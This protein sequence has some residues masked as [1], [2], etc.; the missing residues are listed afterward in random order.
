MLCL[1]GCDAGTGSRTAR[2]H[3]QRDGPD[4]NGT[5]IDPFGGAAIFAGVLR[6]VSSSFSEDPLRVLRVARFAARFGFVVAP[7]TEA[8]MRELSASGELA[9]L[10]P[11][12]VWQELSRG[13]MEES[14]RGCWVLCDCGAL[15][16]LLPEID[17][18][19]G[20]LN[21]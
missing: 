2:H 12:R 13:L 20:C 15:A 7:A 4:E 16:A 10:S 14:Y 19:Y 3:H 17:A 5:L 8:L 21:R 1:A 18:L 11:E 6:H 9:E